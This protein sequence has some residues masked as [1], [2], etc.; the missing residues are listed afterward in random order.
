MVQPQERRGDGE[1]GGV[2]MGLSRY[3]AVI[4]RVG[5]AA[6]RAGRSPDSITLVAVS[7]GRTVGEIRDL[8]EAGHRDFGEN[9]AQEMAEKQGELPTDIRW[10][11]VGSL[12]TNKVRLIRDSTF[13]LHSLDRR[14][15]V[16]AWAKGIGRPPPALIQVN[17]GEEGQ[18]GGV[19]PSEVARLVENVA[20]LGI[21]VRGLMAI[22]P[23]GRRA[24]DSR[25]FFVMLRELR[26]E[27]AV[28][29]P[30]ITDLSMGMTDDFEVGIIEGASFIRVG[31]AIFGPR[32]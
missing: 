3:E 30:T 12:Q 22:P 20:D 10:H 21:A 26:D 17:V 8:Y 7:K 18:K 13:L 15:L 2:G 19:A 14:S 1:N 16:S 32:H 24:E 29:H 9:R 27:L 6:A 11:F 28:R 25:R 23:L 5:S 31:R 4:D